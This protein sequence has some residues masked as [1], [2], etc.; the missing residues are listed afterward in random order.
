MDILAILAFRVANAMAMKTFFDPDEFYQSHEIAH[1][2]VY[3]YGYKTWEW[4][5]GLRSFL[6]PALLIP[7]YYF[8]PKFAYIIVKVLFS[9]FLLSRGSFLKLTIFRFV[10]GLYYL[11]IK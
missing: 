1:S 2:A 3:G 9:F 6:H 7:A 5:V 11:G 8:S 4:D 10:Q